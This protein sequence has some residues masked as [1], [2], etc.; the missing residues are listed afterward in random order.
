M[1]GRDHFSA[2]NRSAYLAD[3]RVRDR[4]Q[5]IRNAK[6]IAMCLFLLVLA[7]GCGALSYFMLAYTDAIAASTR[8]HR[9]LIGTLGIMGGLISFG[10]LLLMPFV[11]MGIVDE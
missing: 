9:N 1:F 11:A 5:A 8:D 6:R 10:S 3:R 7:V 2:P 4:R